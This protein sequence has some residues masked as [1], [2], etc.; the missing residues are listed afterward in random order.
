MLGRYGFLR[1]V[2][3][4]AELD[5]LVLDEL[6]YVPPPRSP[7]FFDLSAPYERTSLIVNRGT[8]ENSENAKR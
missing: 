6:G 1:L 2:G 7:I 4:T 3:Q 8:A 5:L